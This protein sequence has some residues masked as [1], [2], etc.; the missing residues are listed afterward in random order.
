MTNTTM[1]WKATVSSNILKEI[2]LEF[3]IVYAKWI[4]FSDKYKDVYVCSNCGKVYQMFKWK[5][6]GIVCAGNPQF[7]SSICPNCCARMSF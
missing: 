6:T 2:K 5:D 3:P 4:L 7:H 1:R